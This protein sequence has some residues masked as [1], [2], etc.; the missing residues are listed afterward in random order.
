MAKF[1]T[2]LRGHKNTAWVSVC[3]L[4]SI[5]M[6]HGYSWIKTDSRGR[7]LNEIALRLM[8]SYPFRSRCAVHLFFVQIMVIVPC[9]AH[10]YSKRHIMDTIA[11]CKDNWIPP[12]T[13]IYTLTLPPN[14]NPNPNLYWC[15]KYG[16][17]TQIIDSLLVETELAQL[18]MRSTTSML[19]QYL[20]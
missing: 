14:P 7:L 13:Y 2:S 18:R 1:S 16:T 19:P 11:Y 5:F 20:K 17:I 3:F 10:Q 8:G 6:I 15:A 4:S 9:F 12:Y